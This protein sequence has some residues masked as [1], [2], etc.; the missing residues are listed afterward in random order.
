MRPRMPVHT[1]SLPPL[2]EVGDD[3]EW[4][5]GV[6]PCIS[7]IQAAAAQL[8]KESDVV[9]IS[10]T[11]SGKTLTFWMST[12]YDKNTNSRTILVTCHSLEH[13]GET[14]NRYPEQS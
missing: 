10:G 3:T 9:Y 6:R 1:P 11:G 14:N 4:V 12:L 8:E 13:F 7:Q 2:S 5:F